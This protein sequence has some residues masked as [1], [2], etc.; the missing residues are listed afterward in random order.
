MSAVESLAAASHDVRV[1]AL[2]L[3]DE[4]SAPMHAREIERALCRAGFSRSQA[5]PIVK[6]LKHLP[7][8]AIGAGKS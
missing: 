1:L 7:V 6:V 4:I 8:I 3:M 5:R 2:E